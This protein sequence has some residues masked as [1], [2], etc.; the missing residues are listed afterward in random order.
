MIET[1]KAHGV[2]KFLSWN[3]SHLSFLLPEWYIT[4]R[5]GN[6]IE[7]Y[8]CER[9]YHRVLSLDGIDIGQFNPNWRG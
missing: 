6:E 4:S 3:A 7:E 1:M 8:M 9:K 5:A 2:K